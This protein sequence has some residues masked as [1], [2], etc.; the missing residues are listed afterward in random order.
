MSNTLLET[1]YV[2]S[3]GSS[4]FASDANSMLIGSCCCRHWGRAVGS[5]Q[6]IVSG[7]SYVYVYSIEY[8]VPTTSRPNAL[9]QAR[10]H[11]S[12]A[13]AASMP[14]PSATDA[15]KIVACAI[16]DGASA[17]SNAPAHMVLVLQRFDQ[18]NIAMPVFTIEHWVLEH[19]ASMW[20]TALVAAVPA[21][22]LSQ[23]VCLGWRCCCLLLP[24]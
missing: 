18:Y 2:C 20:V 16:D 11:S 24:R 13:T 15:L 3:T 19:R 7:E 10:L 8:H 21:Q 5:A 6:V 23:M 1:M 22:Q 17:A 9:I 14:D 12:I 4:C